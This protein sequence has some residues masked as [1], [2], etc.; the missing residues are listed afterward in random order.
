MT[1][2]DPV[3]STPKLPLD[4][5]GGPVFTAPWEAKVFAMTLQAYESG[6]FTWPEWAETLGAELAKDRDGSGEML[7]YYDH[8]L[9]AFETLL[10]RKEVADAS[11]LQGLRDAW[12]KAAKSTPHGQPIVLGN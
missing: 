5:D 12:D 2:P 6:V 9:N 10:T 3:L 4:Q 8:W 1:L 7:S 11:Q